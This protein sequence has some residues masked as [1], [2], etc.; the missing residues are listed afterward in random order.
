MS[1]GMPV[2]YYLKYPTGKKIKATEKTT[3]E[4]LIKTLKGE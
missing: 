2:L 1:E 3:K 4:E